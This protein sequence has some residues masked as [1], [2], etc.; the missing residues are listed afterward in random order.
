MMIGKAP[1]GRT[2]THEVFPPY[3]AVARPGTGI[4]PRTPQNLTFMHGGEDAPRANLSL[5]FPFS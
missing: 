2:S 5:S 4:D 3:L 1:F